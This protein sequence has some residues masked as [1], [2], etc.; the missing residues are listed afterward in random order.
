MKQGIWFN[1]KSSFFFIFLAFNQPFLP[2]MPSTV[3]LFSLWQ[4]V[5]LQWYT[6]RW[7]KKYF[8][9]FP[10][11]KR[12]CCSTAI[13]RNKCGLL[14]FFLGNRRCPK[15]M[16]TDW[17]DDCPY[18]QMPFR[19]TNTGCYSFGR[20]HNSAWLLNYS[21]RTRKISF[22]AFLKQQFCLHQRKLSIN[23]HYTTILKKQLL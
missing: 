4:I 1:C 18:M 14:F 10:I 17:F 6:V 22:M 12:L 23:C 13:I 2:L 21:S 3:G 9:T 20:E 19:G 7:T 8:L 16:N 11:L 5:Q 15:Q